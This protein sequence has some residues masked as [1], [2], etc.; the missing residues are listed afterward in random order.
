MNWQQKARI[1]NLIGALPLSNAI[2]Y[3]VQRS[4]GSLRKGQANPV[5]YYDAARRMAAWSRATGRDVEG[6]RF[7]EVGTGRNVNLPTALW[8]C[9]AEHVTTVDLN[10]YLS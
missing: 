8:L 3:A 1:Q 6:M 5:E 4:V 9:G 10:P 2:Y 7:L